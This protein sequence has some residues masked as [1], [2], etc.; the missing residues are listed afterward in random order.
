MP[1]ALK[2]IVRLGRHF[3]GKYRRATFAQEGEDILL[4]RLM[5]GQKSGFYV[6]VGA[7]HP[8]KCSNT[9]YFYKRGWR[10]INIDAMPGSM[11]LFNLLRPRDINIEIAISDKQEVLEFHAF[12]NPLFNSADKEIAESRRTAFGEERSKKNVFQVQAHTLESVL[13]RYLPINTEIDFLSIDVEGLDLNVLK[14]NNWSKFRPKYILVEIL[15]E[16]LHTILDTETYK[17]LVETGYEPMS[18][19]VHTVLFTDKSHWH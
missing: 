10:G 6:D 18:K 5:D 9:Y 4:A 15:D 19:L 7:H 12:N 11:K 13:E 17:F 3:T 8:S 16:S 1:N 2:N 14:S